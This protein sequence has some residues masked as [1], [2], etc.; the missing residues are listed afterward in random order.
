MPGQSHL[1]TDYGSTCGQ[2]PSFAA[3]SCLWPCYQR[4]F[5]TLTQTVITIR[6]LFVTSVLHSCSVPVLSLSNGFPT[7][8]AANG[9][10]LA[11]K[12]CIEP[13]SQHL[14]LTFFAVYLIR[15]PLNAV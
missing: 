7:P 2:K 12:F 4:I 13:T 6:L 5:A 15:V 14:G 10:A 3:F 1:F 9:D 11:N 8:Q